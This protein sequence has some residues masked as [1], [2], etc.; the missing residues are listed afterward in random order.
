MACEPK[1]KDFA[2]LVVKI[3]AQYFP[4]DEWKPDVISDCSNLRV[5]KPHCEQW[6]EKHIGEHPQV[7]YNVITHQRFKS[8]IKTLLE[9]FHNKAART[10]DR[11][12]VN[13]LCYCPKGTKRAVGVARCFAHFLIHHGNEVHEVVHLSMDD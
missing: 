4:Y 7:L 10:D 11:G 1:N 5:V 8:V 6:N 9:D 12:E 2:S 13:V 3:Q